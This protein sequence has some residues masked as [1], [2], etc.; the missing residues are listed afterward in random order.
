MSRVPNPM[1]RPSEP[2]DI[3]KIQP[4]IAS[5]VDAGSDLLRRHHF[6]ASALAKEQSG[7]L[8]E[9]MLVGAAPG[10]KKHHGKHGGDEEERVH[11]RLN[12]TGN[13]FYATT[14][15]EVK[16]ATKELFDAVTVLFSAMTTALAQKGKNLFDFDA[17]TKVV[18]GSGYFVEVQ[19]FRKT[20]QIES[21][22]L[23]LDTQIV[24][25]LIPGLTSSSSLDIAKSVLAALSGQYSRE[26]TTS[27]TKLGHILFIC[28]E[29]LGAPSV[30]VRIFFA[31]QDTMKKVT[32]SPCHKSV[33]TSFEM[34][35]EASTFLFVSPES[36]AHHAKRFTK[37]PEEYTKLI[38][39]LSNLVPAK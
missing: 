32:S 6:A 29:L 15:K 27:T 14:T 39:T 1:P 30:T 25:Q 5:F 31:S 20:L 33:S 17:W 16:D 34:D 38:S 24:Q 13:I 2:L 19:K 10:G 21:D 22:S 12:Q 18:A 9:H 4:R 26:G 7:F 23:S 37:H 28:E 11:Y 8:M 35:Q 3:R 36:I